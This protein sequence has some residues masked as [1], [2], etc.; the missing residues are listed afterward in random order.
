MA[1]FTVAGHEF[2]AGHLEEALEQAIAKAQGLADAGHV[3]SANC[4]ANAA[5]NMLAIH[6]G[7]R[8]ASAPLRSRVAVR[9]R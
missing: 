8:I 4:L 9:S 2:D 5:R 6:F 1:E 7:R 3:A